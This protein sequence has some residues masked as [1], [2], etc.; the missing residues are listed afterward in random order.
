MNAPLRILLLTVRPENFSSSRILEA[1]SKAGHDVVVKK[2]TR[3][4]LTL[5]GQLQHGKR[6]PYDAIIPRIGGPIVSYGATVVRSFEQRGVFSTTSSFGLVHSKDKFLT[7]QILASND[8]QTPRTTTFANI[9]DYP[10]ALEH[11][12]GYPIIVKLLKSSQGRAVIFV[13][14]HKT[15]K[16]LVDALISQREP[17]LMQEF[18]KEANGSDLRCFVVDGKVVGAMMRT[19]AEGD[20]RSNVHQGGTVKKVNLTTEERRASIKA[21]KILKLNV[22]G[23]D[24]LRSSSG[25]KILEVNSSPGL[26][27]IEKATGKDIAKEIISSIETNVRSV[28]RTSKT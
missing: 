18:V 11:L 15:G 24:I 27:G 2:T 26:E 7:G 28:S 10:I 12:G 19:A 9:D 17:F 16:S 21:A 25:P 1:A 3:V 14:N 5:D 6:E 4:G 22:A 8:L 23:V 13:D 20:F